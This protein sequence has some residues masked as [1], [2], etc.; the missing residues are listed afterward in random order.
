M[1]VIA[2][3]I[4]FE[5]H[6]LINPG[7]LHNLDEGFDVYATQ[8]FNAPDGAAYEVSWVG[9]PDTAYPTDNENWANCLSQVKKLSIRDGKLIQEP[10]ETIKSLRRNAEKIN[11]KVIKENTTGQYELKLNIGANQNGCLHLAANN[12]LSQS[13]QIKFDTKD[14][15]LTLDR[16][17]AGKQVAVDY[18]TTRSTSF[19]PHEDLK[20]N[21][22][23]DHS[24]VEIFVN[25]GEHVLTG[26]FFT[27]PVNQ[28]IEF[29]QDIDYQGKF[30]NMETIL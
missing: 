21:I 28:R 12:D 22:F 10:A 3:D 20:L 27:D 23:V 8:A 4:D 6:K 11:S 18:G 19:T 2:D 13:L 15:K 17:Q 5:N 30:Y 25:D 24:L 7:Q 16:A 29:D 14:G 9:L 26:R 1:Y